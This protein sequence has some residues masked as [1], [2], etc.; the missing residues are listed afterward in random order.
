MLSI[1]RG[2]SVKQLNREVVKYIGFLVLSILLM[3]KL[4]HGSLKMI[5][6]LIPPIRFGHS[7]LELGGIIPI[8]LFV[9]AVQGL[10]RQEFIKGRNKV[11]LAI[12]FLG[13]ISLFTS[14]FR[15]VGSVYYRTIN[16]IRSIVFE[17]S[18]I[19]ITEQTDEGVLVKVDLKVRDYSKKGNVLTV[20]MH[21]PDS[22]E[23]AFG[24]KQLTFK[25]KFYTKGD[26]SVLK[27]DQEFKL[28]FKQE[29]SA[30]NFEHSDWYFD[31]FKYELR[32]EERKNILTARGV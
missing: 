13:S 32:S 12:L 28:L 5:E 10:L 25:E 17:N 22:F 18:D 21:L 23:A 15:A 29:D 4:P 24:V 14:S 1:G 2:E 9:V 7:M 6:Y 3:T 8:I 30:E 20:V 19:Y 26:G 16:D 31:T 27:I 11:A